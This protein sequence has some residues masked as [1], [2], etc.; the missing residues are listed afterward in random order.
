M[1]RALDSIEAVNLAA[2]RLKEACLRLCPDDIGLA[3][4]TAYNE[5]LAEGVKPEERE[6][7]EKLQ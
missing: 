5:H 6:L 2:D 1:C 7:L 3:L 4:R